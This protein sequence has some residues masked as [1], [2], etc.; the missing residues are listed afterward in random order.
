MERET[1]CPRCGHTDRPVGPWNGE[2]GFTQLCGPCKVEVTFTPERM[3]RLSR[4]IEA[5][6]RA[7]DALQIVPAPAAPTTTDGGSFD[8]T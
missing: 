4:D 3:R 6:M 8:G 5:V 2:G 1:T 7:A